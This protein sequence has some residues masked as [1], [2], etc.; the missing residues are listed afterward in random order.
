MAILKKR[1]KG[2][3]GRLRP[4]LFG[5]SVSVLVLA[6]CG[7]TSS[8]TSSSKT[9]TTTSSSSSSSTNAS[10]N[11][12]ATASVQLSKYLATQTPSPPGP[13]FDASKAAGKLVWLVSQTLSTGSAGEQA[14]LITADLQ[15]EHVNV[16]GCSAHGVSTNIGSCILQGLSHHP[17]AIIVNGGDPASYTSATQ[18]ANAAHVPV[19][20]ELDVP[21]PYAP[22]S[23]QIQSHLKGISSDA[24]PPDPI[25]GT[26]AA[27]FVV[28]DSNGK[29]N[30]LFITSPGIL[31]GTY[32]E[33]N[34]AARMKQLCPK[35]NLYVKG[36]TI[37]N[38]A[39]DIGPTVSSEL[40]LHPSINYVVPVFDPMLAWAGPAIVQAGKQGTVKVVSVNG[41]LQE[42]QQ[43]AQN[44]VIVCDIG[45]DYPEM[46][47]QA[48]DETL[49]Y[50]SG[51]PPTDL[52][53]AAQAGVRVFT[54]SNIHSVSLTPSGFANGSWYTGSSTA[55]ANM[56]YKLWSGS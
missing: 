21:V 41:D 20:S 36:V 34:F 14:K 46:A 48:V 22:Y 39:T 6:A 47:F 33:L 40:R 8:A 31:G 24:A 7:S 10:A 53:K 32:E 52:V 17:A 16:L 45:Q 4:S 26:L 35:C 51:V 43:L 56:Y 1:C 30:V 3:G 19:I 13:A 55:L 49:R 29:A 44:Q 11:G 38:W 28:K 27:D 25:S 2:G 42:M 9:A 18:S 5:L 50:L 15:H 23:S 37:P 12:I 54:A